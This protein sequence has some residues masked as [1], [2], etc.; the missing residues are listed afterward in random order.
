MIRTA[1]QLARSLIWLST[2]TRPDIAYAQCRI[3]SMATTNP[4]KAILDARRVLRYLSGTMDVGL[5]YRKTKSGEIDVTAFGDA[6]FSVRRSQSGTLVKLAGCAV[7]WKSGKQ[8][9]VAK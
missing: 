9:Q 3:S 5:V 6:N 2:R 1:Q 4:E 8:P 7:S